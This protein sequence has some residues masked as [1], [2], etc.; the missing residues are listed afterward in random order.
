MYIC[1][2]S[3]CFPMVKCFAFNEQGHPT[4]EEGQLAESKH[5]ITR[6]FHKRQLQWIT[7]MLPYL[8]VQHHDNKQPNLSTKTQQPDF[9]VYTASNTQSLLSPLTTVCSPC[10]SECSNCEVGGHCG[11][12]MHG[13]AA[14]FCDPY[15]PREL[16]SEGCPSARAGGRLG[17]C[18]SCRDVG[19]WIR[20]ASSQNVWYLAE[21]LL[22]RVIGP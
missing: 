2:I 8:C 10:R 14:T 20:I 9:R 13:N 16:V 1:K 7:F 15:G 3:T 18:A 19:I 5:W 4:L 6:A 17:S 12:I 11:V 21:M 22:S